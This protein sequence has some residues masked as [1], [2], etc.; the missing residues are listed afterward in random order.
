MLRHKWV[1][2]N[3]VIS[4]QASEQRGRSRQDEQLIIFLVADSVLRYEMGQRPDPFKVESGPMR[5]K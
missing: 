1:C 2:S 4:Q 5:F 3:R